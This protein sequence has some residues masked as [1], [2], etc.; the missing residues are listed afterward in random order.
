MK[1]YDVF[2]SSNR[3]V[4]I[5]T[6]FKNS[7][8]IPCDKKD[9]PNYYLGIKIYPDGKFEEIYNGPGM[10][11]WNLVKNRETTKIGLHNVAL[12]T[13]RELNKNIKADRKII[14]Y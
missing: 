3:K 1:N 5:K 12:N 11:I 6:T 13:L 4:Q 14:R 8:G 9:V 2:T 10:V 7:L